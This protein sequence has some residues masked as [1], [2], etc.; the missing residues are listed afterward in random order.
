MK[1]R[2]RMA[3]LAPLT[4]SPLPLGPAASAHAAAAPPRVPAATCAVSDEL[5]YGGGSQLKVT[6]SGFYAGKTVTVKG[7]N[8]YRTGFE[9]VKANCSAKQPNTLGEVDPNWQKGYDNGAALAA[10]TFCGGGT[11]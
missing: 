1:Q 7:D 11:Q 6:G 5:S 9:G 3:V 8:G 2:V 10:K 4:V